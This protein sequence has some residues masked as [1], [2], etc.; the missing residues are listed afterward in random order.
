MGKRQKLFLSTNKMQV[1]HPL[2]LHHRND[3]LEIP[4]IP[5]TIAYT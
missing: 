2:Q 1:S 5:L 4:I 3:I